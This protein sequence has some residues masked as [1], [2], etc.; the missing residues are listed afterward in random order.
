MDLIKIKEAIDQAFSKNGY[1]ISKFSIFIPNSTTIKVEKKDNSVQVLFLNNLP[2]VKTKKL[3]LSIKAEVEGII[4]GQDGGS[5]K[6]KHFPDIN[7]SYNEDTTEQRFGSPPL[8]NLE[9]IKQ[10]IATQYPDNKRKTVA[11]LALNYANEWATLASNGGVDFKQCDE[12]SKKQLYQDCK[13]FVY[14]NIINSKK[15]EP[16][17]SSVALI[18]LYFFLPAII[19]WVVKRFLDQLVKKPSLYFTA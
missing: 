8:V 16:K 15:V 12:K 2:A 6:L 7:F 1:S 4:L 9:K 3:F 11:E 18:L 17:S 14:E 5:I 10:E 19:N 13:N